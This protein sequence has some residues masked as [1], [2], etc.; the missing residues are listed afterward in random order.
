MDDRTR[1]VEQ[2]KEGVDK[3]VNDHGARYATVLVTFDDAS[4]VELHAQSIRPDQRGDDE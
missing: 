4:Q 3:L 2:I 1:I